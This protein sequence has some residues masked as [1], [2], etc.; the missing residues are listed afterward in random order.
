MASAAGRVVLAPSASRNRLAW[1]MVLAA[2]LAVGGGLWYAHARG[3][4]GA[5]YRWAG[6]LGGRKDANRVSMAFVSQ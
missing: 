4:L 3:W 6:Q 2:I 5:T 1:L